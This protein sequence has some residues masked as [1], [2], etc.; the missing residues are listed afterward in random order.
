[1]IAANNTIIHK[2][3]GKKFLSPEKYYNNLIIYSVLK[4]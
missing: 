2:S 3:P 4:K 1:M